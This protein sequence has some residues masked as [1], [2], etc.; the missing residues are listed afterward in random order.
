[1]SMCLR[2]KLEEFIHTSKANIEKIFSEAKRNA[3]INMDMEKVAE[4]EKLEKSLRFVTPV[5]TKYKP[6]EYITALRSHSLILSIASQIALEVASLGINPKIDYAIME[7]LN[8]LETSQGMDI[9]G[10]LT[11][12]KEILSKIDGGE[13]I[14]IEAC[15]KYIVTIIVGCGY[16][17]L[18]EKEKN[19]LAEIIAYKIRESERP[20]VTTKELSMTVSVNEKKVYDIIKELQKIYPNIVM[21]DNIVTTFDKLEKWAREVIE[22]REGTQHFDELKA[23]FPSQIEKAYFKTIKRTL[24]KIESLIS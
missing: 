19:L 10:I 22:R 20:Y 3:L 2:K 14:F 9:G 13:S 4:F 23:I 24:D 16:R 1:M 5:P 15:R 18:S 6:D 11:R 17:E 12:G 21:K 8:L 7:I